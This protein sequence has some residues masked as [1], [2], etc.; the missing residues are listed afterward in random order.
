MPSLWTCLRTYPQR[1]IKNWTLHVV[2][3]STGKCAAESRR[4]ETIFIVLSFLPPSTEGHTGFE[5]PLH[6][7]GPT[8]TFPRV[9]NYLP[10]LAV[11]SNTFLFAERLYV[12]TYLKPYCLARR[13]RS[14]PQCSLVARVPQSH[15]RGPT[16]T[17]P[18]PWRQCGLTALPIMRLRP[19]RT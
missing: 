5:D 19:P 12:L 16:M 3:K 11:F 8:D 4:S 18:R 2:P 9:D 13:P 6:K 1:R 17:P 7:E 14:R 10:H 15:G